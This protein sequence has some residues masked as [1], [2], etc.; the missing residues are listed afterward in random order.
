MKPNGD[1]QTIFRGGEGKDLG[2]RFV[3]RLDTPHP[4]VFAGR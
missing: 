4:F 1:W 3:M 2:L